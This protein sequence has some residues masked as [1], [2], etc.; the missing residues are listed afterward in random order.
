MVARV[1]ILLLP[2][3]LLGPASLSSLHPARAASVEPA[4]RCASTKHSHPR[5][6]ISAAYKQRAPEQSAPTLPIVERS[7]GQVEI[8][9][10]GP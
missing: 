5:V 3:L 1:V 10:F 4:H 2:A 8:L 7:V 9:S 6:K